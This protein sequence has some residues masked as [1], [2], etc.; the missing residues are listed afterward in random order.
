M[1][2]KRDVNVY[3]LFLQ[4]AVRISALQTFEIIQSAELERIPLSLANQKR[5]QLRKRKT[6]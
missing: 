3:V 4:K 2:V 5:F 6:I 1:E